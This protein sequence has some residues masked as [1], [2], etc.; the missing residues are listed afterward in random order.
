MKTFSVWCIC[1]ILA[2]VLSDCKHPASPVPG[3][4]ASSVGEDVYT[5]IV[6]YDCPFQQADKSLYFVDYQTIKP[7]GQLKLYINDRSIRDS[8]STNPAWQQFINTVDTSQFSTQTL[9]NSFLTTCYRTQL[10]TPAQQT[11]YFA[12]N[13]THSTEELRQTFPAFRAILRFSS[14][15]YASDG[16]KA[17]CYRATYCG[18][19]CASGSAY[20]LERSS[21]SWKV[22][23]SILIWTA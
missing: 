23:R 9:N 1:L 11:D 13:S 17:V 3:P 19:D 2:T 20:L 16:S 4:P 10:L 7:D 6:N 14:V 21:S 18:F 12:P 15:I 8:I 5:A 22:V